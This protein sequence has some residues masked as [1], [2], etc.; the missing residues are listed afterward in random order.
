TIESCLDKLGISE[1]QV[2]SYLEIHLLTLPGWAGMMLWKDES[3]NLLTD[4]LAIRLALEWTLMSEHA[5]EQQHTDYDISQVRSW[6]E[7][8]ILTLENWF[9]LSQS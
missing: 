2:Q 7:S 9:A 5:Q 4:Y 3:L 1:A 8:G 6:F